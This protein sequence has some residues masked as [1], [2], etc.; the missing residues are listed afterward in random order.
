MVTR[1]TSLAS[2]AFEHARD[3]ATG[4]TATDR[5]PLW[6]WWNILSI[7]A[8]AVAGIWAIVFA[9]AARIT[10]P[11]A[12]VLALT[13]SVWLIYV[14]DRILDG[15][16]SAD[17]ETLRERHRFY[18]RHP[19][20]TIGCW[21]IVLVA[22]LWLVRERLEPAIAQNGLQLAVIVGAYFICVHADCERVFR[23]LPKEAAVGMIFAAGTVAPAWTHLRGAS[24]GMIAPLCL[25]GALCT[26]NCIAIECWENHRP[27]GAW[28][29]M[30]HRLIVWADSRIHLLAAGLA[31]GALLL[32]LLPFTRGISGG[33]L[34]AVSV[35]AVLL[36]ALNTQ[37]ERLSSNALRVL[38]DTAL[39]VPALLALAAGF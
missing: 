4:R 23:V 16:R 7:D 13:A 17:S 30:P 19:L 29:K 14:A 36:G 38:A 39:L 8:P 31:V 5:T 9:R 37:R 24:T 12:E 15:W 2:T 1:S 28:R 3:S 21:A 25:F 22:T 10:L 32:D 34:P 35:S 20:S 26:L 6:L 27:R 11:A 18:K 33:L